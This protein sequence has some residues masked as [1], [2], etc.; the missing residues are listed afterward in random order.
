M[1]QRGIGRQVSGFLSFS[2]AGLGR[3]CSS[4]EH[5]RLE[6]WVVQGRWTKD[7][8]VKG[9]FNINTPLPYSVAVSLN[10]KVWAFHTGKCYSINF[11]D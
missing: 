3:Y 7:C 11:L 4:A 6:F 2:H 9:G 8:G 5:H 10:M 1:V